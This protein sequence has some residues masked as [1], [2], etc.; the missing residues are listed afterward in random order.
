MAY[1]TFPRFRVYIQN[2]YT[3][4][5]KRNRSSAGSVKKGITNKATEENFSDAEAQAMVIAEVASVLKH[6]TRNR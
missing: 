5:V 4:Q 3:K 2:E 6:R 1:D